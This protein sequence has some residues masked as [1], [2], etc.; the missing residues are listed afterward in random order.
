MCFFIVWMSSIF[1]YNIEKNKNKEKSLN[2]EKLCLTDTVY[3]FSYLS[4]SPGTKVRRAGIF[5]MKR[6]KEVSVIWNA[7]KFLTISFKIMVGIRNSWNDCIIFREWCQCHHVEHNVSR[8]CSTG[9]CT[10]L[11]NPKSL[12]QMFQ[13][14]PVC[15]W[16][17]GGCGWSVR[18]KKRGGWRCWKNIGDLMLFWETNKGA[19]VAHHVRHVVLWVATQ[20]W[21]MWG[22]TSESPLSSVSQLSKR[23]MKLNQEEQQQVCMC[24]TVCLW[25]TACA[26]V[27]KVFGRL[28]RS[29]QLSCL[30]ITSRQKQAQQT[31][32]RESNITF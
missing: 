11:W 27:I 30:V 13:S 22:M 26:F 10:F 3:H 16:S 12:G 6:Y 21:Q 7:G 25:V 24:A 19:N 9:V 32:E 29:E 14:L 20:S 5:Q 2:N 1:I 4:C 8:R 17:P 18:E 23:V 15:D 31:E 28:S